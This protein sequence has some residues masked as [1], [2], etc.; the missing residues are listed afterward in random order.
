M[1]A[2]LSTRLVYVLQKA[3]M[4]M[5]AQALMQSPRRPRPT[6]DEALSRT[7]AL[8]TEQWSNI[9]AVAEALLKD[10]DGRL[11]YARTCALI[12]AHEAS[13]E[14][15]SLTWDDEARLGSALT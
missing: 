7:R 6:L 11:G 15:K 3:D 1:Q 13:K 14:W 5:A 10:P 8:V 2:S 4:L 9:E 12:R